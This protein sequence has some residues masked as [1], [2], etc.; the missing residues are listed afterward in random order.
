MATAWKVLGQAAPAAATLTD[1]YTVPFQTEAICQV[2]VTNRG[3]YSTTF[4]VAVAPDGA[5]DATGHYV[6]YD[7]TIGA[8]NTYSSPKLTLNGTDVVRVY[9]TNSVLTFILLGME[10]T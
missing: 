10:R 9:A 2:V 4:R 7:L 8:G 1:L 3:R 5:S 6:V